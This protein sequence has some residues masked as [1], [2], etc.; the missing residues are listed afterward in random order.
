M[1]NMR[2][3]HKAPRHMGILQVSS[4]HQSDKQITNL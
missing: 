3:V 1:R 2:R 4:Q